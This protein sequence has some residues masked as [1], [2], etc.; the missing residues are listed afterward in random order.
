MGTAPARAVA[1]TLVAVAGCGAP[2][3]TDASC[4][5]TQACLSAQCISR[6]IQPPDPGASLVRDGS[7]LV[8]ALRGELGVYVSRSSDGATWGTMSSLADGSARAPVIGGAAAGPLLAAYA[9]PGSDG[10][11]AV[12]GLADLRYVD[13]GD[14]GRTWSE[15]RKIDPSPFGHGVPHGRIVQ[16]PSGRLFLPAD[17]WYASDNGALPADLE[18]TFASL[19]MMD[20]RV[21]GWSQPY[22]IARGWRQPVISF[23]DDD[24]LIALLRND[25]NDIAVS[26]SYDRGITWTRPSVILP[27]APPPA[28]LVRLDDGR[29]MISF[30]GSCAAATQPDGTPVPSST[31][32]DVEVILSDDGGDGWGLPARKALVAHPAAADFGAI[33]APGHAGALHT[34]L[35]STPLDVDRW[36]ESD[37]AAVRCAA[38]GSGRQL[39]IDDALTER[40]DGIEYR[41]GTP[42]KTGEVLIKSDRPWESMIAGNYPTVIADGGRVRLWYEAYDIDGYARGDYSA[43]LCYAESVGGGPF[44]KPDL[45]IV[46]FDGSSVTNIVFPTD[47]SWA[48]HGG[49][50]FVDP[51]AGPE[52]RYKL[53]GVGDNGLRLSV[54]PDGT[55]FT[56]LD[57]IAL[58]IT[59]D[60]QN[61]AYWDPDL[62]RYALF[63]RGHDG[64]NGAGA[65]NIRRAET[66]DF[67]YASE[68]RVIMSADDKDPPHSDLYNSAAS[69]Y[70]F[71]ASAYFMFVSLF[72]QVEQTIQVQ[73]AV[74]RDGTHFSRVRDP[75]WLPV[76]AP[77]AFD[78]RLLYQ[79]PGVVRDGDNLYVYYAGFDY[80]HDGPPAPIVRAGTVSRARIRL[81][82]FREARAAGTGTLT[83]IPVRFSGGHLHVNSIGRVR[84]ALLDMSGQPY[85][86]FSLADSTPATGDATDGE[87]GFA[88]DLSTL[89][90]KWVRVQFELSGASLYAFQFRD[91]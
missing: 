11:G 8:I 1:L 88:A 15:P 32:G 72:N 47:L 20:P 66:G 17:L 29:L 35:G 81:D 31:G 77:G 76:G 24:H 90:G 21:E 53:Y 39:F 64:M 52:Q 75:F 60:T 23:V 51:S 40:S 59:S 27:A 65:R 19:F 12:L 74:S 4:G 73:L 3:S 48:H 9:L 85:P 67:I 56:R 33:S 30:S 61:V 80:P 25:A 45:G 28:D 41:W 87:I 42:Q 34:L 71:A 55:H 86:G 2:C 10:K 79:A 58:P 18:G 6:A 68:P 46:P 69:K 49:T 13:S 63:L 57:P 44:V 7:D 82:G 50:V 14:G 62:N 38:I 36:H 84:A 43:K 5:A 78:S 26:A 22:V 70:P 89:A 54:S 83:T 37:V 16:T 91:G